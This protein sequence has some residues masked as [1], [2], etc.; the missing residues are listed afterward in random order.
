MLHDPYFVVFMLFSF[1]KF[2]NHLFS[3]KFAGYNLIASNKKKDEE[4]IWVPS[5]VDLARDVIEGISIIE[6]SVSICC[7]KDEQLCGNGILVD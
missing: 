2:Y 7:Q 1:S 6:I 3:S 4:C 5:F